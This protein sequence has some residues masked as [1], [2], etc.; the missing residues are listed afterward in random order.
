MTSS[1]SLPLMTLPVEP[2]YWMSTCTAI[3]YAATVAEALSHCTAFA[4][5]HSCVRVC[6]HARG[7]LC[8]GM[9]AHMQCNGH[10]NG[11][12]LLRVERDD[13]VRVAIDNPPCA[14][15]GS[16]LTCAGAGRRRRPTA[17]AAGAGRWASWVV[18]FSSGCA[19][20]LC[21]SGCALVRSSVCAPVHRRPAD[22]CVRA[23]VLRVE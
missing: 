7:W 8:A 13:Q 1:R 9:G 19:F 21:A 14:R 17:R 5:C 15:R 10:R 2:S 4:A 12:D 11:S 23:R 6:A 22:V 18:W 3:G 16:W 20:S